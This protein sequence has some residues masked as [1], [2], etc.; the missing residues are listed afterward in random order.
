[1]AGRP[2]IHHWLIDS[3]PDPQNSSVFQARCI[4]CY[5]E[6]T[7]PVHAQLL[8]PPEDDRVSLW[9]TGPREMPRRN[10]L[11][12]PLGLTGSLSELL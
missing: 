9:E 5:S 4:H 1:M 8:I 10:S 12:D 6:T 11:L 3:D 7:F 2:C